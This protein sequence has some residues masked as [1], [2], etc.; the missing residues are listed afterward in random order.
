M[1]NQSNNLADL[2]KRFNDL[3]N[4]FAS[5]PKLAFAKR[6]NEVDALL[7]ELEEIEPFE[8]IALS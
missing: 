6:S 1:T 7:K 4:R 8:G 2:E 3:E 5:R